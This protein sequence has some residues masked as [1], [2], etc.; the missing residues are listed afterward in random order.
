MNSRQPQRR[1]RPE[2]AATLDAFAAL[3]LARRIACA[4]A[5]RDG[6]R[7]PNGALYD[8]RAMDKEQEDAPAN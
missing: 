5:L 4:Q 7:P 2:D 1:P 8:T 6:R 3:T